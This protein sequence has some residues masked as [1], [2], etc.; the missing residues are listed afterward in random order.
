MESMVRMYTAHAA[1]EDT[2]VF[3]AWKKEQPKKRLDDLAEKFEEIEHQQFGKDGFDDAVAR[4]SRIE[5]TLGLEK[6]DH[7]TAP[8]PP[9]SG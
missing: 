7:Y 9:Q 5:W 8:P 2:V 3:P 6:L 4:I 1:W